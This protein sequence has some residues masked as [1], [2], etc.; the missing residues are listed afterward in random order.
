MGLRP[1]LAPDQQAELFDPVPDLVPVEPEERGR[2][3]L[4][5]G[6]P[7]RRAVWSLGLPGKT[8]AGY[9]AGHNLVPGA[10]YGSTTFDEYLEAKYRRGSEES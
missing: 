2:T 8:V 9:A 1:G 10:P 5:A 7:S 3:G 6:A 4:V